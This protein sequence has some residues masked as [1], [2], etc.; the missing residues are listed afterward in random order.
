MNFDGR[1]YFGSTTNLKRRKQQHFCNMRRG[2][3]SHKMQLEYNRHGQPAFSVVAVFDSV[4]QA[5]LHE[6]EV[7]D[8]HDQSV[9][10]NDLQKVQ[11]NVAAG[12]SVSVV[13][14]GKK[15]NSKRA[16]WLDSGKYCSLTCFCKY[17]E[18]GFTTWAEIRENKAARYNQKKYPFSR[19]IVYFNGRFW[20][21]YEEAMDSSVYPRLYSNGSAI[22]CFRSQVKNG[23]ISDY[24]IYLRR[25]KAYKGKC[26]KTL[27]EA[28]TA[29]KITIKD[30]ADWRASNKEAAAKTERLFAR[31]RTT[32]RYYPRGQKFVV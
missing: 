18:Q 21:S 11:I 17:Y 13:F 16:A 20:K 32:N 1:L 19:L 2:K 12:R 5:R 29:N 24:H 7:I 30:V 8:Q 3:A 14:E 9:L 6:Q 27:K 4:E 26:Y 28:A 31:I 23:A 22:E 15:Y 25:Y 10:V